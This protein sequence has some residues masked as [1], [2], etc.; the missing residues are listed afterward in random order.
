MRRLLWTLVSLAALWS[1]AWLGLTRLGGWY[2][3]RALARDA[4]KGRV[5][6]CAQREVSGFPLAI[7]FWCSDPQ[8]STTS[9]AGTSVLTAKVLRLDFDI[10]S[11]L[12]ARFSAEAPLSAK[13]K[14]GEIV[15]LNAANITG[16]FTAQLAGAD[17]ALRGLQVKLDA[18]D[19]NVT[20]PAGRNFAAKA[21]AAVVRL[22]RRAAGVNDFDVAVDVEAAKIP[23]LEAFTQVAEPAVLH[24]GG[25]L[26]HFAIPGRGSSAEKL[27]AWRQTDGLLTLATA[28]F[29]NGTTQIE[30]S[31]PL[32]LDAE[33]RLSG[34]LALK[35]K[36]ADAVLQRFGIP[37]AALNPGKLLGSLFGKGKKPDAEADGTAATISLPVALHNGKVMIGPLALPLVLQPLY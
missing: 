37:V 27:E 36:G 1:G 2:V 15:T 3:E 30:T 9:P 18:P 17:Q 23:A 34:K 5:W 24:I 8:L 20:S 14:S 21:K 12:E 31:G 25:V 35:L 4:L 26:S 28:T 13:L 11:P 7:H 16:T 32:G 6:A 19:L 29:S 22:D 33:H 10:L